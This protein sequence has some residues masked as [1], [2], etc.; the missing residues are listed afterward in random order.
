MR[1][2]F[3]LINLIAITA[4]LFFGVKLFYLWVIQDLYVV[5]L[6]TQSPETVLVP[7][8]VPP[9]LSAYQ[10]ILRRNL[11]QVETK[12]A[13]IA[14]PK[15]SP[16]ATA[17]STSLDL[18]LWGTATFSGGNG[19][20]VIEDVP[21][22]QQALFAVGEKIRDATLRAILRDRVILSVRGEEQVLRMEDPKSLPERMPPVPVSAPS[23]TSKEI[24]L[25]RSQIDDAIQNVHELM[26]QIKIRPHFLDG[27]PEGLAV[28]GISSDSI[29]SRMGLQN[30]DIITGVNGE[31]IMTVDDALK[32]YQSIKSGSRV[33]VDVKRAGKRQTLVYQIE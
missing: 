32:L 31:Q 3:H 15:T 10:S 21:S 8:Q 17:Q 25:S 19:F 16:V 22:R 23:P 2:Y 30:G 29:F 11:F 27:K 5:S 20:A 1:R 4:A 6:S 9:P 28:G 18:R 12:A 24:T 13:S 7:Q 14:G 26:T 33:N